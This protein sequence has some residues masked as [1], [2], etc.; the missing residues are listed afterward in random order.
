MKTV[1]IDRSRWLHGE[2]GK[3]SKLQRSSDGKRCCVGFVCMAY[4]A[5]E[6][7][8]T[9]KANPRNEELPHAF[10][11]WDFSVTT[12]PGYDALYAAFAINDIPTGQVPGSEQGPFGGSKDIL[13]EAAKYGDGP[14]RDD[15][16]RE[17]RLVKLFAAHNIQLVFEGEYLAP[18]VVL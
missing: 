14:I 4:G 16:D 9:D 3:P 18:P 2:G 10:D 15:A 1:T 8:I 12:S 5:T 13:I 17:A 7:E 11:G 6:A